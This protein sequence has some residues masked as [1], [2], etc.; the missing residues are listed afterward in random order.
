MDVRKPGLMRRASRLRAELA[1]LLIAAA[2]RNADHNRPNDAAW[3]RILAQRLLPRRAREQRL[4]QLAPRLLL[5]SRQV[6]AL[7]HG[8]TNGSRRAAAPHGALP[9]YQSDA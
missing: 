8:A 7:R 9:V 1:S 4:Q 5:A 6:R 2:S 3:T